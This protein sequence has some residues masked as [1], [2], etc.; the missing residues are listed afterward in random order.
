VKQTARQGDRGAGVRAISR[1]PRGEGFWWFAARSLLRRPLRTGLTVLGLS[2]AILGV[3]GLS[4]VS[5]GL[6]SLLSRTLSQVRGVLVLR[7]NA[8]ADLFSELPARLAVPLRSVPGVKVV[9]PQIW[10]FAPPL[11]GRLLFGTR[12]RGSRRAGVGPL[13]GLLNLVQVE[14]QDVKEHAR[15]RVE[16]Y[17]DHLLPADRGGG[18]FLDPSDRGQYHVVLSTTLAAEYPHAD[19]RPRRVGDTIRIGRRD[20]LIVGLYDTGSM[21]LDHTVVMEIDAARQLLG[22]SPETVSCFLLEAAPGATE[23][24]IAWLIKRSYRTLD[25]RTM[26]RLGAGVGAAIDGMNRMLM[27]MVGLA[28]V[29]G[30]LGVLNT[31]I[32]ST[33]ERLLEFGI[34]RCN[35]WSRGDLM[36][37]VLIESLCLGAIAGLAGC[38]MA[39]A[40]VL[41]VNRV[42]AGG[43]QLVLDG[44]NLTTGMAL[45]LGLG[46]LGGLFPAWSVS[47]LSPMDVVR[48]GGR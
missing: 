18:R 7:D 37:L 23:Q 5:D 35:G 41:V 31:M 29:V 10:K 21:L 27:L 8:P 20:C 36:R 46:V 43:F 17:R 3:I 15:L 11:E 25:A 19:G 33:S 34:L 39:E 32:M 1:R 14:G 30:S 24:Q 4:S 48:V 12:S 47:R 42:L 38:L 26:D 40:G 45:A 44:R 9:A 28:L 2:I 16:P 6:R 13:Q 22:V